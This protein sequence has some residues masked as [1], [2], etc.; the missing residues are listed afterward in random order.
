MS[1][2]RYVLNTKGWKCSGTLRK[3]KCVQKFH[4]F[5]KL[6]KIA[7]GAVEEQ[8]NKKSPAPVKKNLLKKSFKIRQNTSELKKISE[9]QLK[10]V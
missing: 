5:A 7:C 4:T 6:K 1:Q 9:N 2:S 3:Q 8:I 10:M